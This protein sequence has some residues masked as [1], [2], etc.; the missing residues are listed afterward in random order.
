MVDIF[1]DGSCIGN[2]GPGGW[3]AIIVQNGATRKLHGREDNTTNNRM[4]ILAAIQGIEATPSGVEVRV[5]SDST[6]LINTMTKGWKRNKNKDLVGQTGLR[7][8]Q[9]KS[10]VEVGQGPRRT[11]AQRTGRP[12][13]EC[14]GAWEESL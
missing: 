9:A 11:P 13:R 6:Y 4:E 8:R 5:H 7:G 12:H 3:A 2:P 1:T 14:R 10:A